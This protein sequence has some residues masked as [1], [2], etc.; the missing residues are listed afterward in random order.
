MTIT[1][2]INAIAETI[3]KTIPA[4]KIYLFGSYAYGTPNQDSDYDFFIVVPDGVM[5]PI[6]AM[7]QAQ[8]ALARRKRSVSIDILAA[9][10]SDFEQMRQKV[11]AIEKQVDQKGVLLYER[12]GRSLQ[13]DEPG[14]Q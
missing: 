7:R 13:M 12:Q 14:A 9:T 4:E 8:R 3:R 10:R 6:E 2:D 11:N 5:R 1:Q